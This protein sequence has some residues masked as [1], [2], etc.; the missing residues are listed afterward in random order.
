MHYT[1]AKKIPFIQWASIQ[2]PNKSKK[3]Q[4]GKNCSSKF[5]KN[6]QMA[7]ELPKN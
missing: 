7:A 6:R 5:A 4:H 2:S 3:Q 1:E